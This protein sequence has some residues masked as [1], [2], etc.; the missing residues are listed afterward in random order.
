MSDNQRPSLDPP[1]AQAKHVTLLPVKYSSVRAA[2]APPC[3]LDDEIAP[4][5]R[6]AHTLSMLIPVYLNTFYATWYI[7]NIS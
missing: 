5:F 3:S 1:T 7:S 4:Y 6:M 2:S